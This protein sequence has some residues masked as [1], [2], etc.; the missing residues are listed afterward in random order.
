MVLGKKIAVA[1]FAG[2][3]LVQGGCALVETKDDIDVNAKDVKILI[4][5]NCELKGKS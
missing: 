2:V 5:V 3:L 4:Y 1:A